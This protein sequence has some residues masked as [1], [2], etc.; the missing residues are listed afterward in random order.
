[1]PDHDWCGSLKF[2]FKNQIVMKQEMFSILTCREWFPDESIYIRQQVIIRITSIDL[3]Y[4]QLGLYF[5]ELR[6]HKLQLS[7]VDM[8]SLLDIIDAKNSFI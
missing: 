1:M 7:D 4:K 3:M 6:E 5:V 8:K 2:T